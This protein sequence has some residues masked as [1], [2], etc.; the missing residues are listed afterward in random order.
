MSKSF[1]LIEVIVAVFLLTVGVGGVYVLVNQ[2]ISSTTLLKN[3]LIAA[4]LA[5]EGI[6]LV[7]N[8]RDTNW[9]GGTDW[10]NGI[11]TSQPCGLDYQD[12]S[13]APPLADTFFTIDSDGFYSYTA[14]I[15]TTFKRIINIEKQDLD[16][17][18]IA[19]MAKVK[20]TVTW[21][22]RGGS[23]NSFTAVE[24]LYNWR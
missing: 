17:D 7:R 20:V 10:L 12:N 13:C 14:G 21:T 1:T 16:G 4:Y 23:Q 3:R 6:E 18:N 8:I 24:H 5:Q 2:A 11:S 15:L 9:L 22:G 19:D